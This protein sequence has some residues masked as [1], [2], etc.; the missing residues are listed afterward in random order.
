[1]AGA[2]WTELLSNR[3]AQCGSGSTVWPSLVARELG[4][5]VRPPALAAWERGAAHAFVEHT[6]PRQPFNKVKNTE[7]DTC[8]K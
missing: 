7:R 4:L 6:L 2:Q 1:M 3:R 8:V 5:S